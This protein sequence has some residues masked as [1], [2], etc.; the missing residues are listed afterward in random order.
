MYQYCLQ[1]SEFSGSNIMDCSN[2]SLLC[3]I[4]GTFISA[5]VTGEQ[6]PVDLG[7]GIF[8]YFLLCM[9]CSKYNDK[10]KREKNTYLG[11]VLLHLALTRASLSRLVL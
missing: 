10:K 3:R 9:S 1:I 11:V 5:I 7:L 8:I 6:L 4:V 2:C